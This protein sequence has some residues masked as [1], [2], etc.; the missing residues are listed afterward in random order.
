M[1][2]GVEGGALGMLAMLTRSYDAGA[3]L[4]ARLQLVADAA[5]SLTGADHA[6]VRLCGDDGRLEPSA[7]AGVGTEGDAPTFVRGQGILGW[8]AEHGRVARVADASADHRFE[9]RADRGFEVRSVLSAPVI[10][11]GDVRAV[12]SASSRAP[13]AFTEEHERAALLLCTISAQELRLRE[14]SERTITDAHTGAYNRGYL[15][16]RLA[17]ELAR[18]RRSGEALSLMLLDLDRFKRVND[19]YGHAAGDEVLRHFVSVVRAVVRAVDVVVR[20]GGEEFVVILPR[21]TAR[22]SA[23]VAERVRARLAERLL[24]LSSGISV[25]QTV[26]IGVA[27]WDGR[28]PAAELEARADRAMYRAKRAGRDRVHVAG[29]VA[30]T[31]G[32]GTL[33]KYD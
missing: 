11:D 25:R 21:A 19:T 8:V 24:P 14:L 28:E 4:P 7:R 6:S 31:I 5:L 16:P 29:R 18:S 10:V 30:P 27:T 2:G 26:S 12:L 13:A 23:A 15:A 22:E 20:R 17:E 9:P 32:R 3:S 1:E 33:G